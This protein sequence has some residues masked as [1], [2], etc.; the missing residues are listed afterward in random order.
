MTN[1][2]SLSSSPAAASTY[3]V[4]WANLPTQEDLIVNLWRDSGLVGAGNTAT[5]RMRL[6][7]FYAEN[8][9]GAAQV[10]LLGFSTE[11][12]PVGCLAVAPRKF[13]VHGE[14]LT[15]GTLVDFVVN[16]KHRSAYPALTLQRAGRERALR[17]WEFV[18]GL[19][20]TKAVAICKRLSTHISFDLP[21]FVRVL[22]SRG[23]LARVLPAPIAAVL[24]WLADSTDRLVTT[25]R[26]LGSRNRGEWLKH[27]DASFDVL[28]SQ[29]DKK[30]LC[31]GL[32]DRTFLQWRF[33]SQPR[34]NYRIFSVTSR[35]TG[36]LRMYFVCEHSSHTLLVKDCLNIASEA[37][38]KHGLLLL[39][40]A[41]RQLGAN[42]VD[43]QLSAD[44]VWRR[45]LER[46]H[47]A[48]RSKRPFFAEFRE[49]LQQKLEGCHWYIT[50]A[51]EDI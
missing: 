30:N 46:T 36:E 10:N 20:D 7:W 31:I 49:P 15:G 4:L 40:K 48:L 6:R 23:Y 19:P 29:L 3:A 51:D 17:S 50:Q 47:F 18:Y 14:P 26:L 45:A 38:L 42:A 43:L 8:P 2:S 21:R 32:R 28:W 34:H 9:Q 24:S 12:L 33:G 22:R 11:K 13:F 16:P 44:P 27:F 5:D 25:T 1:S 41:A 39:V 37:E 35:E